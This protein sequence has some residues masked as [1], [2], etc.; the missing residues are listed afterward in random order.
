MAPEMGCEQVRELAPEIVLGIL[1]GGRPR[2]RAA[3]SNW[4]SP[5]T[6]TSAS[7]FRWRYA[8]GNGLP[9]VA[10]APQDAEL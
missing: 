10:D 7:P 4:S 6:T 9:Y 5:D 3:P 8:Q 1:R 2:C